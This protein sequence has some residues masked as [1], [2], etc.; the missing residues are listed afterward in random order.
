MSQVILSPVATNKYRSIVEEPQMVQN[1][2][3]NSSIIYLDSQASVLET[4]KVNMILSSVKR[5]GEFASNL[6]NS[7]CRLSV[8]SCDLFYCTPNV[9]PTNNNI[10]FYS[11]VTATT[12]S[13]L[14]PMNFYTTASSLMTAIVTAM[15]TVS[16]SS[17]L[18]FSQSA[19]SYSP[20]MFNLNA[21]GGSFYILPTCNAVTNGQQLYNL[22]NSTTLVTTTLVGNMALYYTRFIDICSSRLN[23][24]SKHQSLSN[25]GTIN[26]VFRIFVDDPTKI[27]WIGQAFNFRVSYAFDPSDSITYIDF[28]LRDQFGNLLYIPPGPDGTNSGFNWDL[29]INVQI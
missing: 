4:N 21:A 22:P 26:I 10:I 7:I 1:R 25:N 23:Q 2:P 20:S 13:V 18:T 8:D 15:N 9:N 5:P 6:T 28:Q 11:S 14:I 19:V 3:P 16:G 29:N 17:S 12:Y 24:Y 27:H